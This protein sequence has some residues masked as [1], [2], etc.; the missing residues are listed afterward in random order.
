M[1]FSSEPFSLLCFPHM[2]FLPRSFTISVWPS[3]LPPRKGACLLCGSVKSRHSPEGTTT[4]S[5]A[6]AWLLWSCVQLTRRETELR[7]S[8]VPTSISCEVWS[9]S[10]N[11]HSALCLPSVRRVTSFKTPPPPLLLCPLKKKP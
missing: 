4:A 3:S 10:L 1:W 6:P 9:L 7:L 11:H 8:F 5:L 2:L